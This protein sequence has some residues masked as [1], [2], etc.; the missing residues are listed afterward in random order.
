MR[1][2]IQ[3]WMFLFVTMVLLMVTMATLA[4][5][6]P[7]V[8][9]TSS[10]KQDSTTTTHAITMPSGITAGDLIL[11]VFSMDAGITHSLLSITSGSNWIEHGYYSQGFVGGAVY[12][13]IAE[14]S[15]ALTL[16]SSSARTSSHVVYRF[17]NATAVAGTGVIGN[18]TNSDPPSYNAGLG[19]REVLWL[20]ARSGD[21]NVI[22][23]AAPSGYSSL[24]EIQAANT[25]GVSTSTAYLATSLTSENPGAF[26]VASEQYVVWSLA[27]FEDVDIVSVTKGGGTF[28]TASP[29]TQAWSTPSN[30]ATLNATAT[31]ADLDGESSQMLKATNFDFGLPSGAVIERVHLT[32]H[33]NMESGGGAGYVLDETLQ[34]IIGGTL[35]GTNFADTG[36]NWP[37]S[38]SIYTP[39][40]YPRVGSNTWGNSLTSAI[41]NASDFGVAIQARE[42]DSSARDA[43]VDYIEMEVRY[44]APLDTPKTTYVDCS[45]GVNGDGSSASP[46]NSPANWQTGEAKNLVYWKEVHTTIF[47]GTTACAGLYISS[48]AGWASNNTYRII[49]TVEGGNRHQG[50]WSTSL[51]R[52]EATGGTWGVEFDGIHGSVINMQIKHF[53][54][55]FTRGG[56]RFN[57]SSAGT[58]V[59]DGN[60]IQIEIDGSVNDENGISTGDSTTGTHLISNNIIYGAD[61]TGDGA[62]AINLG[63]NTKAYVYH[64][65]IVDNDNGIRFDG[66]TGPQTAYNN[67]FDGNLVA[68]SNAG[69]LLESTVNADY[70]IIS[71]ASQT[72]AG[73]ND[74][75]SAT[76]NFDGSTYLLD[77]VADNTDTVISGNNLYSDANLPITYDVLGDP[78]PVSGDVTAGAHELITYTPP[79]NSVL[80][81]LLK[82]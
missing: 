62:H 27:V 52:I 73:A 75:L 68:Y 38:N 1:V 70:N 42:D 80:Y 24:V 76:V 46:Y 41:V 45:A 49:W 21:S 23:S 30:A 13:K 12:W 11:V 72:N 59:A 54:D 32:F 3:R 55:F 18:G 53:T 6:Q 19:A 37:E 67:I 15:D 9:S 40:T 78:R 33:R 28:A 8:E 43:R 10:G 22:P 82:E 60:L 34:L 39:R 50:V 2:A 56:I 36:E 81:L 29:G 44:F 69:A 71:N 51:P 7:V 79:T 20:A 61:S 4:N 14:G 77:S 31:I 48:A 66:D 57:A 63:Q 65:T 58:W 17:S 35:T 74:V 25:S 64:N 5:A 47:R 16:T 26:T